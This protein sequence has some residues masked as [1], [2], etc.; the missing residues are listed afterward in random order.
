M[1]PNELDSFSTRSQQPENASKR[2]VYF[3]FQFNVVTMPNTTEQI[4]LHY[5]NIH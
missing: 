4:F 2:Q 5:G 3:Q 1:Y